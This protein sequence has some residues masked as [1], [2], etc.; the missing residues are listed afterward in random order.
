MKRSFFCNRFL[1]L[2]LAFF[3]PMIINIGGEVSPSFLFIAGTFPLWI[4][5]INFKSGTPFR[6]ILNLLLTLIA[7]QIV[8]AAFADTPLIDQVKGILIV[9]SGTLYFMYYYMVY[10]YNRDVVKWAVLGRFL[11]SFVFTNVLA[12]IEGSEFGFWKFQVLPRIVSACLV[13]YL[14]F[15]DI[16]LI[17]RIAPAVFIIVGGVGLATGARSAGLTPLIS[18]AIVFVLQAKDRINFSQ[19]KRKILLGSCFVYLAYA[20]LYVPNVLNGNISGGNTD[21]LKSMENP[22]NPLGLLMAG[23]T[24][25]VVPFLAFLDNPLTGWGYYTPDPNGKYNMMV[26]DAHSNENV[27]SDYVASKPIPGHSGWGYISCSYGILGFLVCFL[28]VKK[29]LFY[30]FKSLVVHDKYMLYRIFASFSFLWNFLFS[31]LPH[32]KTSPSSIA[33]VLVFSSLALRE[34]KEQQHLTECK[35]III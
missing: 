11:A 30:L 25:S 8:W 34:Y 15:C 28:I 5:N 16:K 21:Q 14:W 20:C 12:D 17:T 1:I 23:R 18:G 7:V 4:T 27:S 35:N 13:I 32:F 26:W 24:D 33:I 6:Y 19:V 29:M 10:S 2:A 31:P 22:Y 3:S 9:V